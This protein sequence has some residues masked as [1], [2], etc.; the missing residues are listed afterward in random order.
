MNKISVLMSVYNEEEKDI[1]ASVNSIMNQ[2]Y[3]NFEIIIVNDNPN[4]IKYKNILNKIQK[5]SDKIKIVNNDKNIGLAKSMN[6]AFSLSKGEIIARMDSDDISYPKRFEKELEVINNGFDLVCTR[7]EYID[8]NDDLLNK[9]SDYYSS[10]AIQKI[11]PHAN[12]IHH[13]TV[14]FKRK[15]F[16]TV[17]GYRNFPCSQD[18]DLWLRMLENNSKIY[19]IDEVLL[20]YRVR[21]NSITKSNTMKQILTL[22]YIRNLYNQRKQR[23]VDNY[24]IDNYNNYLEKCGLGNRLVEANYYKYKKIEEDSLIN[25]KN[26]KYICGFIGLF[27]TFINCKFIRK[28]CMNGLKCRLYKKI[29]KKEK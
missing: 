22:S 8:E 13:P 9:E 14:M 21:C 15:I 24:S 12:I 7:Y 10:N 1:L 29:Y 6:K 11:L 26:K 27:K 4:E 25:I 2:S 17:N 28:N 20:K 19:M 3:Q 16:E 23:S 5:M 18:Y